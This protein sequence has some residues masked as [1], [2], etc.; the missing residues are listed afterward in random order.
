MSTLLKENLSVNN[1]GEALIQH[2]IL[3]EFIDSTLKRIPYTFN[4]A[5]NQI[6]IQ[7]GIN[8]KDVE[9]YIEKNPFQRRKF[10]SFEVIEKKIK[11]SKSH[12]DIEKII[13]KKLATIDDFSKVSE[14]IESIKQ[15]Y[16]TVKA[17]RFNFTK[18][19]YLK[20][21]L[22]KSFDVILSDKNL[23]FDFKSIQDINPRVLNI[24]IRQ[25]TL[26]IHKKG[27]P[28]V[29][30]YYSNKNYAIFKIF[31]LMGQHSSDLKEIYDILI[32]P[33]EKL[34][35]QIY[36]DEQYDNPNVFFG[37]YGKDKDVI[38]QNFYISKLKFEEFLKHDGKIALYVEEKEKTIKLKDKRLG[39]EIFEIP[40]DEEKYHRFL[41]DFRYYDY[42]SLMEAKE[43]ANRGIDPYYS[44]YEDFLKKIKKK[45]IDYNNP[46]LESLNIKDLLI[47]IGVKKAIGDNE[48]TT[49][50]EAYNNYI[51]TCED[52]YLKK[53]FTKNTFISH[54]NTLKE[55]KFVSA[56]RRNDKT[57]QLV[58]LKSYSLKELLKVY[59]EKKTLNHILAHLEDLDFSTIKKREF[60][61]VKAKLYF[62][63]NMDILVS[64]NSKLEIDFTKNLLKEDLIYLFQN[65]KEEFQKNYQALI[66][67]KDIYKFTSEND[68]NLLNLLKELKYK[69]LLE[70][71]KEFVIDCLYYF[72]I[73]KKNI[74]FIE[75][76]F[77]IRNRALLEVIPL[78]QG[79]RN[80]F[81][82]HFSKESSISHFNSF[83][84]L[85]FSVFT[86]INS[87]FLY[88]IQKTCQDLIFMFEAAQDLKLIREKFKDKFLGNFEF[89]NIINN[90]KALIEPKLNVHQ[91]FDLILSEI[92]IG[93]SKK[94]KSTTNIDEITK[95]LQE[96]LKD[97]YSNQSE[98]EDTTKNIED[99]LKAKLTPAL[100]Y[101]K[102]LKKINSYFKQDITS[103]KDINKIISFI[104][105]KIQEE[106]E[107]KKK[108]QSIL[109]DIRNTYTMKIDNT[110]K[111]THIV[112][113][114]NKGFNNLT[115]E[116]DVEM[117]KEYIEKNLA[118]TFNT[119]SQQQSLLRQI[120]QSF[121]NKMENPNEL[122]DITKL[123]FAVIRLLLSDTVWHNIL[124]ASVFGLFVLA[125]DKDKDIP[126]GSICNL[127]KIQHTSFNLHIK[128]IIKD[129][130]DKKGK[131]RFKDL[132]VKN[133]ETRDKVRFR[134]V[135]LLIGSQIYLIFKT[136]EDKTKQAN[137][138]NLTNE[139]EFQLKFFKRYKQ[140]NKAL[141]Q[142]YDVLI[143]RFIKDYSQGRDFIQDN[144]TY[145]IEFFKNN[146]NKSIQNKMPEII[147]YKEIGK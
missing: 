94:K 81:R 67:Q 145:R 107:N 27:P 103:E 135:E 19:R 101:S 78:V 10:L 40:F 49:I 82:K 44:H 61:D 77:E 89:T 25:G 102:T 123:C 64:R 120:D 30:K 57:E 63:D 105:N 15:M 130:I 115:V 127:L 70:F 47:L 59:N 43:K 116:A 1:K 76:R 93:L 2:S 46:F 8:E 50:K 79:V 83:F 39:F 28:K 21:F 13:K 142:I 143:N 12:E 90:I 111:Y 29:V 32:T 91:D 126:L 128:K 37:K 33:N 109:K 36:Q 141:T 14:I 113:H 26:L 18:S 73:L 62:M 95:L 108:F 69:S 72:S 23:V 134:L 31:L 92:E 38:S 9:D 118:D 66:L 136:Q 131:Q 98:F 55:K 74:N 85:K 65:A 119:T 122:E 104:E 4:D 68:K 114:I 35:N 48:K 125:I 80:A 88:K 139:Y 56:R 124:T 5:E 117:I 106:F 60:F 11:K 129:N 24:T 6:Q 53:T 112:K 71:N 144:L 140:F 138:K 51:K 133:E 42:D 146:F 137:L 3:K 84:N 16:E 86:E 147:N 54:I 17:F 121:K 45:E 58:Y 100:D 22:N 41:L 75:N 87:Q 132:G 99:I 52:V 97:T 34:I 110:K 20:R 7:I 96:Q